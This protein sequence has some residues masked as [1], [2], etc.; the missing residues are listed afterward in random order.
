MKTIDKDLSW[1][2]DDLVE[3]IHTIVA[4]HWADL[5]NPDRVRLVSGI[6]RRVVAD[7][8]QAH[9]VVTQAR[10]FLS[11]RGTTLSSRASSLSSR[12]LAW[13]R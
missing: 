13:R 3:D 10:R 12:W 5:S 4:R 8:L 9:Q 6:A 1:L 7:Q 11:S 2:V